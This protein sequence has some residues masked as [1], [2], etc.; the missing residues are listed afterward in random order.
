MKKMS[1]SRFK[2]IVKNVQ[3][4][5]YENVTLSGFKMLF[6]FIGNEWRPNVVRI[7]DIFIE[8]RICNTNQVENVCAVF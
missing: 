2:M 3:C 4:L 7:L 6:S 8:N 1:I 5:K